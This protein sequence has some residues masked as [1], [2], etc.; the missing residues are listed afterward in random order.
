[1]NANTI[2]DNLA[3]DSMPKPPR[4]PKRKRGRGLSKFEIWAWSPVVSFQVGLT[5]G[6]LAMIYFGV[7]AFIAQIPAFRHTAPDGWSVYWAAALTIGSILASIGSVS[8]L[9]W[10]EMTELIGSIL[11]TLTVGSYAAVLLF[12]AYAGQE[13]DRAAGGAGF[14]VL[15]VPVLVRMLW[16]A[17]QSLRKR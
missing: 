13:A 10:F 7:S 1:M 6:Y 16:L 3:F 4:V 14:V 11:V 8:R 2:S 9:K 5:A 17:S 15:T 12:L